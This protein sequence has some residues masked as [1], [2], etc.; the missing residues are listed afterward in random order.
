MKKQLIYFVLC[1]AIPVIVI[2]WWWGMFASVTIQQIQ[3][4]AYHYAYLEVEGPY[5]KLGSKQAEVGAILKAQQVN[6]SDPLTLMMSDPRVTQYKQ[7]I[8]RVGY[9][10]Q[11]NSQVN[12]PLKADTIPARHVLAVSIKAHPVF[13]YGKAYGALV[14]YCQQHAMSLQLPTVE[15][16]QHSVLTVHMP[17]RKE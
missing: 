5:S 6:Y 4:P 16:V 2:L 3:A 10:I 7:R 15:I 17:I 11:P 13:A 14:E 12:A 1:C 8:A 9:L